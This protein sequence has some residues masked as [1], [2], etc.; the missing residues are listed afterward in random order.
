[1]ERTLTKNEF[2]KDWSGD[3][4]RNGEFMFNLDYED[5]QIGDEITL[6]SVDDPGFYLVNWIKSEYIDLIMVDVD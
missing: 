6:D 5:L 2:L 1:M 3:T 4:W